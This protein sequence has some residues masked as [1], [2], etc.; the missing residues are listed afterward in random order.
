MTLSD[1]QHI[2]QLIE[3]AKQ[4]DLGS[5][6]LSSQLLLDPDA[7]ASFRLIAKQPC[8]LAGCEIAQSILHAY[9]TNIKIQWGE[10]IEDGSL[11]SQIPTQLATLKGP[12]SVILSAERV[13][14]NFLQRLCGIA[15]LT[16]T[17]VDAIASTKASIF[18]TRKTTPGWRSLEKYAVRCGGGKNHRMG[19]FDA[20][21]IKD[22][23][24]ADVDEN[25]T[26]P[27]VFALLNKLAS[28]ETKPDFVEIEADTLIQVSELF[29]VVGIDVILLDNFSIADLRQ[30]VQ[31]RDE[32]GLNDKMMLE[33][34]GGITLDTVLSVAQTGVDRI[35]VGALTHSASAI[36]L[37]L[38]RIE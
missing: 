29:K 5:G 1:N 19:L 13:L 15:T 35:S 18:D 16:R 2:K 9:D 23:H 17:Y 27:T 8:I 37:S 22:N 4:E 10:S 30:A 11:I 6:D 36:D 28:S 7:P 3:L 31:M 34:S 32:L 24:I 12:V 21:L 33:A 25:R 38:E 20:V 14:L 26:A